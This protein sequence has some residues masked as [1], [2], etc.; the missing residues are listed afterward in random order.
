MSRK[1]SKGKRRRANEKRHRQPGTVDGPAEF[2][3][4]MV[5]EQRMFVVGYTEG[6]APYG[7]FEYELDDDAFGSVTTDPFS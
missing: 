4:I 3:W 2:D 6:G 1:P 7:C 5:G